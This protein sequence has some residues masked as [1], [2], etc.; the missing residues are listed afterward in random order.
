MRTWPASGGVVEDGQQTASGTITFQ[1]VDLIDTHL[2]GQELTGGSASAKIGR[3]AC[4]ERLLGTVA[5]T[6]HEDKTD[7]NNEGTVHWT[8]ATD[9]ALA[10]DLA[11]N[12]V[13]THTYPVSIDDH[14]AG[15]ITQ[16]VTVTITEAEAA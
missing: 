3:A 10:H 15:T 8:F 11:V 13:T 12:Q 7:T 6:L 4:R 16:D 5:L 2:I 14:H 1:D 9:N